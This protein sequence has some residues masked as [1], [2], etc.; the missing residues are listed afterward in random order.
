MEK[1]CSVCG[2]VVAFDKCPLNRCLSTVCALHQC[3]LLAR[4]LTCQCVQHRC[5]A[6]HVVTYCVCKSQPTVIAGAFTLV[7][8]SAV[9][10]H[11]RCFNF[12]TRDSC[13]LALADQ[14]SDTAQATKAS[15]CALAYHAQDSRLA[16]AL[17]NGNVQCFRHV[18][19]S[20]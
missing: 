12:E 10:T 5:A 17:S 20:R 18:D 19:E 15:P 4:L 3:G 2:Q 16:V 7:C 8:A 6:C 1:R 14:D 11:L 13:R 9:D